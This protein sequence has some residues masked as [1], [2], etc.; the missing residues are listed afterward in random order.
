MK[1]ETIANPAPEF[2][3]IEQSG[4]LDGAWFGKRGG[5]VV[6]KFWFESDAV[7]WRAN[8]PLNKGTIDELVEREELR[9]Q[10]MAERAPK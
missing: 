1:T 5:K 8:D 9:G 7:E 10:M 4:H 2:R 3:T 6:A